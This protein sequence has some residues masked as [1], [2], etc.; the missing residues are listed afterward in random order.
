MDL[1]SRIAMVAAGGAI[2]ALARYAI[3]AS[4]LGSLT[5]KFP[6]PTFVANIV[7]SFLIGF[8]LILLS[9]RFEVSDNVRLLV[10]VGFLGAFT[11]FSTFELEIWTLIQKGS[12]AHSIF[13]LV[14][15]VTAGFA[16]LLLGVWLGRQV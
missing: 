12:Y 2:G 4:R 6:A 5:D 13:Y 14:S 3:S 8:L 15:S 16:A 7:G 9:D 10:F 11:T 1:I